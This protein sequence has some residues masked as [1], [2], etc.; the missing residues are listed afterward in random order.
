MICAN[1]RISAV[2]ILCC[3]IL[4]SSSI[5]SQSNKNIGEKFLDDAHIYLN[6]GVSYFTSPL[7]FSADDW[8]LTGLTIASTIL[9]FH[10]DEKI[11]GAV[12][13]K[14]AATSNGDFWDIP[15]LYGVVEYA[16]IASIATYGMGLLTGEDEVRKVGRMLFQSISYSGIA[17]ISLRILFG[18]EKPYSGSGAWGFTWMNFDDEVQSFPSG[19]ATVA[20][21]FS[22]VLAEYFD[23]I[24]SRVFFYG[25][26]S[27]GGFARI[28]DNQHW[29]SDIVVG[30][31]LGLT[32][33]FHTINEENKRENNTGS[34]LSFN[35]GF[36]RIGIK[37]AI[38]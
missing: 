15:T 7:R 2:T 20:F 8:A 5:L 25:M 18:R 1:I 26:A 13:R 14:N 30:A 38:W 36:N 6:D 29:F 12:S 16:N 22:T 10:L 28:Y 11:Q 4:S 27:L 33:G 23:T 35:I 32:A 37:Y 34:K 19:H 3:I 9:L 21:A 17:V 24:L 31:L